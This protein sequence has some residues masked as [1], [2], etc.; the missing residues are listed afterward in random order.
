MLGIVGKVSF[1]FYPFSTLIATQK[2]L[3]RKKEADEDGDKIS[4]STKK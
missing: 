1:G 2:P 4:S 3:L